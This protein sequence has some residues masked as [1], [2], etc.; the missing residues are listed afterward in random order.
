MS[1]AHSESSITPGLMAINTFT[2]KNPDTAAGFEEHFTS[3]VAFMRDQEGFLAHQMTRGD[4]SPERYVNVGWWRAPQDFGKVA[5]SEEFQ[6][7]ARSFHQLVDVEVTPS[8]SVHIHEAAGLVG[9]DSADHPVVVVERFT[10]ADPDA[11]LARRF[12]AY[13]ATVPDGALA[14]A[15]LGV[16]LPNPLLFTAV[17]RWRSVEAYEHAQTS[18]EFQALGQ[19]ATVTEEVSGSPV[20]AGR[21]AFVSAVRS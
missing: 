3:H 8:R 10:V 20:L 17:S 15:A 1:L 12:I 16:S 9:E 5:Q 2:L 4:R 7:H 11:D 19:A 18:A 6:L 21:S 14:W 13:L